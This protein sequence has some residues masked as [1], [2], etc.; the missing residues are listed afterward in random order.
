MHKEKDQDMY[1]LYEEYKGTL[2]QCRK[3]LRKRQELNATMR[4]IFKNPFYR[5]DYNLNKND[6]S[7]W[8]SMIKDLE[9]DM[10]MIEMYLDFDDRE[11]LHRDYNNMKSM[12]LN[13]NS[14]EGEV[15]LETLYGES[16]PDTTDI[17]YDVELQEEIAELLDEVLTDRQKQVIEMY[18]W[19]GMTQEK[20][21]K[22]LGINQSTVMRNLKDSLDVLR[23]YIKIE[24]IYE[25]LL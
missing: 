13:K 14:Y 17:I 6:I 1:K 21:G 12:I 15:P 18:Y 23:K 2:K 10:K 5:E 9:E 25:N 8:N 11:L 16:T 19:N 4:E 7:N 3:P 24:D 20:I 22:K